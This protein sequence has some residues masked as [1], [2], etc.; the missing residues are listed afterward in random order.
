MSCGRKREWSRRWSVLLLALVWAALLGLTASA[1]SEPVATIGSRKYGSLES[2]VKNVKNGQTVQLAKSVTLKK[3]VKV[4]KNVKFTLDLNKKTLQSQ[5]SDKEFL[6]I[7]TGTVT[8]KNGTVKAPSKGSIEVKKQG[9]LTVSGVKFQNVTVSSCGT[10]QIKKASFSMDS[11]SALSQQGGKMTIDNAKV[12]LSGSRGNCVYTEGGSLTIKGGTYSSSVSNYPVLFITGKKTT[13]AVSGGTFSTK[14]SSAAFVQEGAAA[15]FSGGT[16]K[17][18]GI[19]Y[20]EDVDGAF[21]S[22]PALYTGKNAKV[23]VSGG[24]YESFHGESAEVWKG[25]LKV[26][27]GTFKTTCCVDPYMGPAVGV[28][29]GG[30]LTISKGTVKAK[31]GPAI[32]GFSGSSITIKGGKIYAEESDYWSAA[33]I[34][35][36]KFKKF[37]MTGGN[38]TLKNTNYYGED[39]AFYQKVAAVKINEKKNTGKF[40]CDTSLISKVKNGKRVVWTD[41]SIK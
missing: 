40:V 23:T 7:G 6:V 5:L 29:D 38:I 11:R 20:S 25:T 34:L 32:G 27:G 8:L 30:A 10:A 2:A 26:S 14:E 3:A 31:Y 4:S 28:Y 22:N 35:E 36:K 39:P 12:E 37:R 41:K 16:F 17:T 1:A 24:T 18:S 21:S 15:R 19:T 13:A 9:S 33:V